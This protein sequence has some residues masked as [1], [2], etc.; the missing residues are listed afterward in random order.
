VLDSSERP[1]PVNIQSLSL[2]VAGEHRWIS[3]GKEPEKYT[4]GEINRSPDFMFSLK[5]RYHGGTTVEQG[6]RWFGRIIQAL[7]RVIPD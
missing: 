5:A 6:A 3:G 7:K 2:R 4:T 1:Y